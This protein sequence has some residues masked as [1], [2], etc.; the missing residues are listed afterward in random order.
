MTGREQARERE[1]AQEPGRAPGRARGRE[2]ELYAVA[3]AVPD[4][5]LPVLTLAELGVLR[6]VRLTADGGA[7]VELTP[8]YTGCPAVETMAD[9]I[10]A[11]L[12]GAGVPRVAVRTVLTPPWSTD[13]ITDTGCRKL[14]AAGIAPPRPGGLLT[15]AIHCPRCDA[16]D[17]PVLSRFSGT[18][19]MELRRCA[20]C[21]E[22]FDHM[23]EI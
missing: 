13:D 11:A 23:K 10:T 22:P 5:E 16:V 17:T 7:E 12:R 14:R 2:A 21:R 6:A 4:P 3:G 1:R 15:L 8:T 18:A 19:C 20:A 9:D